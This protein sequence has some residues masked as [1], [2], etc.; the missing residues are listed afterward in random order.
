MTTADARD[1]AAE[2][3]P[4][5]RVIGAYFARIDAGEAVS[6]EQL[7]TQHPRAA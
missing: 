2:I 3:T 4:L 6:R 7:L 5:D 1:A